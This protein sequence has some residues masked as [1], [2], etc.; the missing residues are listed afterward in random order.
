MY[1]KKETPSDPLRKYVDCYWVAKA[2]GDK[3]LRVV[4]PS[5]NI[6]LCIHLGHSSNCRLLPSEFYKGRGVS[7]DA[8]IKWVN[9]NP[10]TAQM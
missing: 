8:I 6:S 5:T 7:L 10:T 9:T 4:S 1:F 3:V 2:D